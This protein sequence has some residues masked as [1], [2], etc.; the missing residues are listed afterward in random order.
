LEVDTVTALIDALDPE[1]DAVP[2]LARVRAELRSVSGDPRFG[3]E[4]IDAVLGRISVPSAAVARLVFCSASLLGDAG[5][6]DEAWR[7]CDQG[8]AMLDLVGDVDRWGSV[9]VASPRAT[10]LLRSDTADGARSAAELARRQVEA[11]TTDGDRADALLRLA[12]AASAVGG[13][14]VAELN[15]N[16]SMLARRAGDHVLVHADRENVGQAEFFALGALLSFPLIAKQVYIIIRFRQALRDSRGASTQPTSAVA[17]FMVMV[18]LNPQVW[19]AVGLLGFGAY[20]LFSHTLGPS[21][22]SFSW[23]VAVGTPILGAVWLFGQRRRK[24]L[25]SAKGNASTHVA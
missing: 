22:I 15:A 11:A 5:P 17:L 24:R 6:L 19:L 14:D 23:G 8:E 2:G 18:L 21:A 16:V 7:R 13:D 25:A 20:Y 1:T 3:C 12:L 4:E 10:L 9:R